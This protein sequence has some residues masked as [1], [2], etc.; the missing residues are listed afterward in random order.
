MMVPILSTKLFIPNQD[1]NRVVLRPRLSER[2]QEGLS[3]KLSLISAPAGFGKT[4]LICEWIAR[5]EGQVAWLSLDEGDNDLTRF[6]SYLLASLQTVEGGVGQ[7]L[8]V[9][10]QSPQPP[11]VETV[12]TALVNELSSIPQ[13]FILVLDDY[14]VIDSS[15][16]DKS[17]TF[18][19]D[20]LPPQMHL[21]IATREDPSL[22]L[23][24]L[25]A[26]GQLT[27]L[28]VADLRFLPAESAG[29]LNQVMRLNLSID[30]IT[31]LGDKTE[32][33]IT[34]LQLA[35][36]SL[37]SQEDTSSFVK[38][39]TGSHRFVLD[40]LIE[41][42]LNSQPEHIQRFLLSTSIL[43]QLSAPLCDVVLGEKPGTGEKILELLKSAN[44][45][46]IPLDKNQQWYRYH[47][48]FADVLQV[49]L[50]EDKSDYVSELHARAS[51]W[52][53]ENGL[54]ADAIKHAI[55]AED[56]EK[57][58]NL[59]EL[60]WPK[61]EG[62]YQSNQ[63]LGWVKQFP[64]DIIRSRPVLSAGCA[65]E[66][67][68]D[69]DL[70]A[71]EIQLQS[72]E[73]LL[74]SMPDSEPNSGSQQPETIVLDD[75]Q[76]Q[77]L[78]ESIATARAYN[79]QALGDIPG[80]VKYAQKALDLIPAEDELRRSQAKSLLGIAYWAGGDLE[81]AHQCISEN[82]SH[83]YEIKLY[84]EI[85]SLTFVLCEIKIARGQLNE[86][87]QLYEQS[88]E[89][90]KKQ[91]EPVP[92]GTEDLFRG[93]GDVL[94][95]QGDPVA[96]ERYLLTASK[97]GE[98][99]RLTDW[100]NRLRISQA[101]LKEIRGDFEGALDLLEEADRLYMRTPL[102]EVRPIAALRASIWAK[103][104]EV[105]E[106]LAWARMRRLSVNDEITYLGEY[107]HITLVRV[108]ISQFRT[109]QVDS[110]IQDALQLIERLLNAA[111]AGGRIGSIIKIRVLK[112]VAYEALDNLP[113]ALLS[114]QQALTLAHSEGYVSSFI[115]EGQPMSSLL[116]E[117]KDQVALQEYIDKLLS[118]CKPTTTRMGSV[119]ERAVIS[120]V[121]PLTEPL[122][123]RELEILQLVADGFS[124]KDICKKLFIAMGT[125]KGHNL[126][127]FTKMNVKRRT[128][129]V[130]RARELGLIEG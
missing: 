37:Q 118:G 13:K 80:T 32:G 66:Y 53:E 7:E 52:F 35:A 108:L 23:A 125:V 123:K 94:C 6:V 3:G 48:L 55:S 76:F 86:A 50:L 77:K 60:A 83:L 10:L 59:A 119:T 81:A 61:L 85:I 29:F 109:H 15:P 88:I 100:Q 90:A 1:L 30:D 82:V 4:T 47:H 110:A 126:K 56:Y 73:N 127:I 117:S 95:E 38:S 129:A 62:V 18:L 57:A 19:L 92:Y 113:S 43:D 102:P 105:S 130:A 24:R 16:I 87:V 78:P 99:T 36:I 5:N 58:A 91:G 72:V 74:E 46:I 97:L 104:G 112:A 106:A 41:D 12:L 20:H 17:V 115:E 2:L 34:G 96:A 49:R 64:E 26:K 9:A 8:L 14:H 33:W 21:A 69:G 89:L 103:Q 22:P 11:P 31:A 98:E 75:E 107:E 120:S 71:A 114:L 27:E 128:E 79:A 116:E 45:F 63:W 84:S 40:Y 28:R 124:N 67:L 39:F 54:A 51:Q 42:V 111:E 93:L 101:R 68:N 122:S 25:R 65:W 44:L 70:E 121:R